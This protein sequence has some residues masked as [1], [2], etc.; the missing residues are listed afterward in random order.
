MG[1]DGAEV[2]WATEL[3]EGYCGPSVSKGRVFVF[4]RLVGEETGCIEAETGHL[5]WEKQ[6]QRAMLICSVTMV[7]HLSPVVCDDCVITYGVEGLL[8]AGG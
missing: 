7:V 4:D 3:G 5:L 8:H 2:C 1:K 6:L